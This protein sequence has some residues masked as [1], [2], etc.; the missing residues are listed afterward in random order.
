MSPSTFLFRPNVACFVSTTKTIS[1]SAEYIRNILPFLNSR[2]SWTSRAS[3][4]HTG[5]RSITLSPVDFIT[6][7]A[8]PFYKTRYYSGTNLCHGC[9]LEIR[10]ISW[11][12][13]YTTVSLLKILMY[14]RCVS[15]KPSLLD[16]K[17]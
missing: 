5:S 2:M 4:T 8:V 17:C 14:S 12:L 1:T 10:A 3:Q 11:L 6:T 16:I 7:N 13:S 15:M 9:I